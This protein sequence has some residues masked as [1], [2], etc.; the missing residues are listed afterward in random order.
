M[1]IAP[2]RKQ[3][4]FN[5]TECVLVVVNALESEAIREPRRFFA[6]FFLKKYREKQHHTIR[7]QG[8]Q[9]NPSKTFSKKPIK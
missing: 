8:N 9:K 5:H 4:D 3:L 6:S 7:R 1:K 2:T